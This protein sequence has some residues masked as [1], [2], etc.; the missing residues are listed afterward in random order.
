MTFE[1]IDQRCIRAFIFQNAV[2]KISFC[3]VMQKYLTPSLEFVDRRQIVDTID[4]DTKAVKQGMI[5][6]TPTQINTMAVLANK[7]ELYW[8]TSRVSCSWLLSYKRYS[9]SKRAFHDI[10]STEI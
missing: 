1:S 9:I 3:K 10:N 6:K 5:Y 7:H 2:G 8:P 4:S